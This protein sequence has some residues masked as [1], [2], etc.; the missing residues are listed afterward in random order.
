MVC[1]AV[2]GLT[3]WSPTASSKS[4]RYSNSDTTSL[5]TLKQH[6]SSSEEEVMVGEVEMESKENKVSNNGTVEEPPSVSATSNEILIYDEEDNSTS[7]NNTTLTSDEKSSPGNSTLAPDDQLDASNN[8]TVSN[9]TAAVDKITTTESSSSNAMEEGDESWVWEPPV[10]QARCEWV[11]ERFQERDAEWN[12]ERLNDRY[13][14]QTEDHNNFFRASAHLFWRDFVDGNWSDV[15]LQDLR[16][17]ATLENG[18]FLD[19]MST[20]TWITGDQH[21][22]NFGSW[23]NRR[24]DIVYGMNDFDESAIY[25][26]Q[27]DVLRI[28][29]S[30]VNHGYTFTFT[31]HHTEEAVKTFTKHYVDTI[32]NYVDNENALEFELTRTNT[33]GELYYFLKDVEDDKS[34]EY[35]MEKYTHLDKKTGKRSFK[36]GTVAKRDKKT[37]LSPI[38]D[39]KAEEIRQ[40]FTSSKF[41]ATMMKLGWNVQSWDDKFFEVLDVAARVGSG[42]ASYGVE[43]YYVLLKGTDGSQKGNSIILDIKYQPTPHVQHVLTPEE[44]AWYSTLFP[45]SAARTVES[46]RS[47]TSYT[48]PFTGWIE[49][50]DD[51]G[52]LQPFSVRQRSPWKDDIEMEDLCDHEDFIEFIPHIGTTSAT[53]HV[54]ATVAK[55][56][57]DFKNVI[58]SLMGTMEQCDA[59]GDRVYLLASTYH[60]QFLLDY[61]CF[62]EYVKANYR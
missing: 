21:L 28:A 42:V 45:N 55:K 46:E 25:D 62:K 17:E 61:Q 37:K 47:L 48:D 24:G 16:N 10:A 27:V 40:A 2:I 57:G 35:Q 14:I 18:V 23:G 29:A 39:E 7:A 32:L 1:L 8:T 3:L 43:R 54:R 13:K 44:Y 59:W 11:V 5:R 38:P 31:D 60:E 19:R 50:K 53:S 52:N 6:E 56:P 49:L 9:N 58:Q 26:F 41:G 4:S 15:L 34:M 36:V 33:D 12:E 22:S 20:W 51:E 30:I